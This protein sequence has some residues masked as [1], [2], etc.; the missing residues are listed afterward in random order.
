MTE[1]DLSLCGRDTIESRMGRF[2][3]GDMWFGN[4][5]KPLSF[6]RWLYAYVNPIV[7][8]DPSGHIPCEGDICGQ[9]PLPP[10]MANLVKFDTSTDGQ[11]GVPKAWTEAEKETVRHAAASIARALAM[12]IDQQAL[13]PVSAVCE[14]LSY[15][16]RRPPRVAESDAFLRVYG[17]P[18]TFR[19]V[20]YGCPEKCWGISLGPQLIRVYSGTVV[21]NN[22][23]FIVHELGHSFESAVTPLVSIAPRVK[24]QA[25]QDANPAF[26]NRIANQQVVD[27]N[28]D[29]VFDDAGNPVMQVPRDYLG[30]FAGTR[31]G[32]QQSADH[33]PGEEFADMFIGWT[34]SQW[35][36][37]AD[38]QLSHAGRLRSDF[39]A[40]NMPFWAWMAYQR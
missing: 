32:W 6:N 28:G 34:Y 24:L 39:M 20:S 10:S 5:E 8:T 36:R 35:E 18:V 21:L 17:G 4:N 33:R 16:Y 23:K 40:D 1:L 2:L 37:N 7:F 22:P 25:A 12:A 14:P 30:G 31:F 13:D 26:P 38:G 9:P 3:T 27:E 11:G 29:P 19:R 15:L